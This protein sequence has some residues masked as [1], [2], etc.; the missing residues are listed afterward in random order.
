VTTPEVS[1]VLPVRNARRWIGDTLASVLAQTLDPAALEVIVV[2]D[3]STDDTTEAARAILEAAGVVHLFLATAGGAG[4]SAARNLGW[5]RGRGAW[6]QFLDGDDL[7]EP[8]KLAHQLDVARRSG[9][10]VAVVFSAWGELVEVG[11]AW[12]PGARPVRPVVGA[13]PLR[14]LLG[15]DNFIATGSQLFRRTWL[16]RVGGFDERLRLVEDVDLMLR[17]A[18]RGGRFVDAASPT[19]LFWYR[20]HAASTSRQSRLQFVNARAR[21][22]RLVEDHWRTERALTPE[23]VAFLTAAYFALAR[24]LADED[25]DAFDAMTRHIATL[26]PSLLPPGP[27]A[28][29]ALSRVCG[30][31]RAE[32]LTRRCRRWL[33]RA[34]RR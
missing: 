1:V 9:D 3:G 27:P 6:V 2:D 32:R 19:P 21:N 34:A 20:R 4:P 30:Y 10:D 29:R 12:R 31:R 11:D 33:R 24:T 14:D 23:R 16:E 15:D 7:V 28:L 25:A 18:V 22:L 17:I 13:D 5:T 26:D 8:A